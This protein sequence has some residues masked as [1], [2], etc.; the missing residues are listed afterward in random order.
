LVPFYEPE[1]GLEP[2]TTVY[3]TVTL[4]VMLYRR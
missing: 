3:E 2:R 1:R 4:P